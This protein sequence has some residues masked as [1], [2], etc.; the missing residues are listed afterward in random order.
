MQGEVVAIDGKSLRHSYDTSKDMG[1]ISMVSAWATANQLVLGQVKVDNK[2]N[3]ITAI[4]EL[5]KVL[6]LNGCIMTIDA[7]GCQTKII[8]DI[9]AP[10]ADYVI[11]LKQNQSSR[12]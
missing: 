5:L 1:A 12:L 8:K 2:S 4:P 6:S 10:Y 11:T 7:I 9:V 3:E